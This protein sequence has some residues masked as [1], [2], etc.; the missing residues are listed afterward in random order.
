MNRRKNSPAKR[1]LKGIL[2]A[3][4]VL[5]V[6]VGGLFGYL[7]VTEYY[8]EEG[9]RE[10]LEINSPLEEEKAASADEREEEQEHEGRPAPEAHHAAH[11]PPAYCQH[12]DERHAHQEYEQ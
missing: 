1:I 12:D 4:G 2:L 10:D 11:G 5:I 8:P 9:K 6:L 3:V 7:T